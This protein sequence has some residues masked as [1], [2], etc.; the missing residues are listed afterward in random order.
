MFWT[1]ILEIL[2]YKIE[3]A[4]MLFELL[5]KFCNYSVLI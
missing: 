4:G 1:V 2:D 5:Q 3:R